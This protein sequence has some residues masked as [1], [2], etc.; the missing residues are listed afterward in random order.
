[1]QEVA[2]WETYNVRELKVQVNEA[3]NESKYLFIWDKLGHVATYFRYQGLLHEFD[4]H[5]QRV[6][7]GRLTAEQAMDDLSQI[8]MGAKGQGQSVLIDLGDKDP[9]FVSEFTSDQHFKASSVFNRAALSDYTDGFT[10]NIRSTVEKEEDLM[11]VMSKI[12][13]IEKFRFII[14]E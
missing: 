13:N 2:S 12:P 9:D 3:R 6:Q 7:A 5:Y 1:M 4:T 14:I 10:L 8:I 11:E